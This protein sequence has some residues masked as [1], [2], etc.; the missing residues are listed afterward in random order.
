MAKCTINTVTG[1]VAFVAVLF[2]NGCTACNIMLPSKKIKVPPY[3]INYYH[4]E[5]PEEAQGEVLPSDQWYEHSWDDTFRMEFKLA[6][7]EISGMYI[8]R[9]LYTAVNGMDEKV[10]LPD[11]NIEL[12][13]SATS[14]P[15]EQVRCWDWQRTSTPCNLATLAPQGKTAKEIRYGYSTD[16]NFAQGLSIRMKGLSFMRGETI[17][18]F[19]ARR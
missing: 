7:V 12:L 14:I 3:V 15:I 9:L 6:R 16:E 4:F 11:P 5:N 1:M 8:Y 2:L 18:D 13:D 17:I 19:Y 10:M